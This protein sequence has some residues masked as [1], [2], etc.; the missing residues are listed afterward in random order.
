LVDRLR[1]DTRPDTEFKL[2]GDGWKALAP[3]PKEPGF[4]SDLASIED[5][6]KDIQDALNRIDTVGRCRLTVSKPVLKAPMV[7]ALELRI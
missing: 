4:T 3:G 1:F 6:K 5:T 7:S 2:K